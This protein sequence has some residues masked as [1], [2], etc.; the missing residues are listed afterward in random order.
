M[1]LI[2][3]GTSFDFVGKRLIA[4]VVSAVL[5][6]TAIGSL[7]VQQLSLGVDFTGGVV[8]EVGYPDAVELSAVRSALAEDGYDEAVVQYF[9]TSSDVL[10]R[11][12]PQE[13]TDSAK[14][15]SQVLAALKKETS[16]VEMR[17]VEFVGAQVGDE[18]TNKG[19][20]ALLYALIGMLIFLIVRFHWK[21]AIGAVTALT[22]DVLITLGVFSLFRIEFDL[23]VI[24]ALLAVIGYSINDTVVVFDRMRENFRRIRKA[25]PAEVINATVNQTLA[26]TAM[27]SL[28]TLLV[29][30]SLQFVG[31]EA[32]HGFSIALIVGV[33]IG[34][35]S[36]IYVA[37]LLAWRLGVTKEDLFPPQDEEGE[38]EQV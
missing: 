16:G 10:I 15:S 19:G 34:T 21:L 33:F 20:L 30:L 23:T 25:T 5:L 22:H 29:L 11:L 27:T 4:V 36:S 35:Y 3:S 38:K 8:V 28:T 12:A 37:S 31:G 14:L 17:R 7:A 13:N 2:P 26:R 32:L 24:A 6:V 1:R 9:G 18:L